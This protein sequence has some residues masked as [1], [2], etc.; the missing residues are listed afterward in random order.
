MSLGTPRRQYRANS[1]VAPP[2]RKESR[3]IYL[4]SLASQGL[5]ISWEPLPSWLTLTL[6]KGAPS[7]QAEAK[8]T[9]SGCRQWEMFQAALMAM[10]GTK[11]HK[12]SSQGGCY[13]TQVCVLSHGANSAF[14]S[15]GQASQPGNSSSL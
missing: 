12:R 7:G 14:H 6:A 4:A 9:E 1:R 13:K 10:V 11:G 3:A 5:R 8:G 15:Q 2:K